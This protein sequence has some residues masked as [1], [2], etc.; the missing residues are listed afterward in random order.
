[1]LPPRRVS[2]A[3]SYA[4]AVL[5]VRALQSLDGPDI[6]P[7]AHTTLLE[8]GSASPLAV[9]LLHG[10]TNH[11]GQYR[12]FAPMLFERGVNVL[13]PRLPR[14]GQRDRMTRRLAGLTAESLLA[15]AG[16]AVDIAHGLGSRVCVAGIS[17][18]GLLCA[19][20]A[21]HRT[22]VARAVCISPVFALLDMPH[23]ASRIAQQ[24]MLHLPNAFLW[25]D[26]RIRG[27]Q[28]PSTAYPRFPTRALAQAMRIGDDVYD[29]SARA[30]FTA[31]SAVVMMNGCDPA[32]NNGATFEV[33][34]RWREYRSGVEAY[35]FSDLPK[36]HD[37]IDPDNPQARTQLVYPRLLDFILATP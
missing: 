28:R 29:A 13:I 16:E 23:W 34:R 2:P 14:Q 20:F 9:V 31:R 10:F 30:A 15:R 18:S 17:T 5:R 35:T 37:I 7:Q 6:L 11:P 32:V 33:V 3:R 12:E 4:E 1:M 19:Y 25:W 24:A 27:K 21:Q 22:D 36:N 26:P 8:H